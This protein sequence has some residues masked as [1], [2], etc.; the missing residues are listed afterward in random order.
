MKQNGWSRFWS[1]VLAIP[2]TVGAAIWGIGSNVPDA[3]NAAAPYIS[4]FKEYVSDVPGW[5]WLLLIAAV[6]FTI[7]RSTNKS[8]AAT[9]SDYQSGRLI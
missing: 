5:V 2:S 9:V 1:K 8:D 4:V 6:G 7:W 3:S